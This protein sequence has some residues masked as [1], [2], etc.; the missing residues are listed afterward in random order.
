MGIMYSNLVSAFDEVCI[1]LDFIFGDINIF[2][3]SNL[4][5]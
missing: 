2:E 1:Q 4:M 5:N 3:P